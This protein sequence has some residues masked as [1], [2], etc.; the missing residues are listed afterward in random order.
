MP[1]KNE[2]ERT[3]PIFRLIRNVRCS[4]YPFSAWRAAASYHLSIAQN[5][6]LSS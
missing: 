2:T 1:T 3:P 6:H 4:S 5:N